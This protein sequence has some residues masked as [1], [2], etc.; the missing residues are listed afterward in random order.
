MKN[1]ERKA[2][3]FSLLFAFALTLVVA[4]A[5]GAEGTPLSEA[6]GIVSATESSQLSRLGETGVMAN[7]VK[8]V[9]GA[10]PERYKSFDNSVVFAP[11]GIADDVRKLVGDRIKQRGY[12]LDDQNTST[13]GVA[14]ILAPFKTTSG[15]TSLELTLIAF[16]RAKAMTI[17]K[18]NP[19]L[20]G[21]PL[22]LQSAVWVSVARLYPPA[23]VDLKKG[24]AD[25][26]TVMALAKL[27]D[28]GFGGFMNTK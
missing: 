5:Q 2:T 16:D 11:A 15:Q 8:P 18:T 4:E 7:L 17:V 3:G 26:A 1:S 27:F 23:D 20:R 12:S 13:A 24:M 22:V 21:L 10:E 19:K 14:S 6:I 28:K 25:E 9:P